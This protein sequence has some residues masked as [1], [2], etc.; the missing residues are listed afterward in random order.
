MKVTVVYAR[1]DRQIVRD[2]DLPAGATVSEAML[3]SGIT[4]EVPDAA[5]AVV[6]IFGHVTSRDTV[7][8]EGDRVEIYRPLNLEPKEARRRRVRRL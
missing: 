5:Q 3:R 4:A 6:G 7:L 1:P 2:I 8:Q